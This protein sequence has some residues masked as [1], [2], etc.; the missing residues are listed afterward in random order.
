MSNSLGELIKQLRIERKLSQQ[1]FAD[2][3]FIDR[4]TCANWESG[5]RM[6]DAPTISRI[7]VCLNV[8][9]SVL[10]YAANNQ[11][12]EANV[13]IV[14]DEPIVL[15]GGIP[16]L[17]KTLPEARITGFSRP[18]EALRYAAENHVHIAFLDI[19]MGKTSGIE[20]CQKLLTI[21]PRTNVIF[22]TAYPDYSL[23]AWDTGASGFLLKPLT[24]DALKKQLLKLRYPIH[25]GV[26]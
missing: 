11:T 24:Q 15:S 7:S 5:R 4:S 1:Q 2:M 9:P 25:G 3:L 17:Q 12:E 20:L 8:D 26:Q 19:E 23:N 10:I 16:I 22:L 21:N 18:S 13:I 6:P 14:D